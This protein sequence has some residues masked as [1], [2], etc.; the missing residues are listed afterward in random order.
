MNFGGGTTHAMSLAELSGWCR[1]RFGAHVVGAQPKMRRFD[2]PWLV[3]DASL[4]RDAWGWQ[5]QTSLYSILDEIALHA[6]QHPRW[7]GL[8]GVA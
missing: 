6:E 3:M 5:P 7:L 4:A 1:D 2:I 8:S